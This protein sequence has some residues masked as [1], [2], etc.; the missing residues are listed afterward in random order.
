MAESGDTSKRWVTIPCAVCAS[1]FSYLHGRG[2]VRRTCVPCAVVRERKRRRKKSFVNERS[3]PEPVL[4]QCAHCGSAFMSTP[5]RRHARV[6]SVECNIRRRRWL[7]KHWRKTHGDGVYPGWWKPPGR[8]AGRLHCTACHEPK[9]AGGSGCES[10]CCRFVYDKRAVVKIY[11]RR[12]RACE[13]CGRAMLPRHLT[14]AAKESGQ[15]RFCS[16]RCFLAGFNPTQRIHADE[17]A[18]FKFHSHNRRARLRGAMVE[19]FVEAEI[20][21]RDNWRCGIC[22]KK[23]DKRLSFPHHMSASLDHIVSLRDGGE[24]SRRNTQCAHWICNSRKT[25][26]SQGQLRLFG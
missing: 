15:G 10:D 23:V 25:F 8:L 24:H 12:S 18:A 9:D 2:R 20:F 21:E 7:G 14:S 26:K 22:G 19:R 11:Q 13:N 1:P 16:S 17:K 4:L 3:L 5:G 6:C